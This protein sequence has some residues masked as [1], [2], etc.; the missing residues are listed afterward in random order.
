[1][2]ERQSETSEI[3]ERIYRY[4]MSETFSCLLAKTEKEGGEMTWANL[5]FKQVNLNDDEN[6]SRRECAL[7]TSDI[8]VD[9]P[10]YD[11]RPF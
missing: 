8:R 4:A 9:R 2:R 1:M 10:Q 5:I 3:N 6:Q 7:I 11:R